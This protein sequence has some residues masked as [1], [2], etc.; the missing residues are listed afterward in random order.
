[1]CSSESSWQ[2]STPMRRVSESQSAERRPDPFRC[3]PASL[4]I[5]PRSPA[6]SKPCLLQYC[7]FSFSLK[8]CCLFKQPG[9]LCIHVLHSCLSK[10]LRKSIHFSPHP[11]AAVCFP[12]S[13]PEKLAFIEWW[14]VFSPNIFTIL[15]QCLVQHTLH[16]SQVWRWRFVISKSVL[17]D[18][19]VCLLA[20]L[21][22]SFGDHSQIFL[23]HWGLHSLVH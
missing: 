23:S 7:G 1:M 20:C 16:L 22:I 12:N 2:L 5:P 14:G 10:T 9:L 21:L 15:N 19:N 18:V 6:L 4:Q 8:W 11:S 17:R 13:K 3:A